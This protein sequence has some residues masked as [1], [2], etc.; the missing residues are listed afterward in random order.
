MSKNDLECFA[1]PG[2]NTPRMA[3]TFG[4]GPPLEES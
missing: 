2:V 3:K 1:N 4:H